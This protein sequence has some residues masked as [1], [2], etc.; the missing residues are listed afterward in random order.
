MRPYLAARLAAIIHVGRSHKE[1]TSL[2]E[3]KLAQIQK[4]LKEEGSL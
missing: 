2:E 4:A 3:A 1:D